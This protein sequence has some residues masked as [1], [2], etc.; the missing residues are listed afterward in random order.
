[1]LDHLTNPRR[2]G[3]RRSAVGL[4]VSLVLHG[5]LAILVLYGIGAAASDHRTPA[6]AT[7]APSI[8]ESPA[9]NGIGGPITTSRYAV[10]TLDLRLAEL[11]PVTTGG[12]PDTMELGRKVPIRF[13]LPADRVGPDSIL[14][15]QTASGDSIALRLSDTRQAT[16]NGAHFVVEPLTPGLQVTN[17]VR[18]SEWLWHVTPTEAGTQPIA[19]QLDAIAKVDGHERVVT[20]AYLPTEVVVHATR[21]QR[22]SRFFSYHWTWLS[23]LTLVALAGWLRMALARR[24]AA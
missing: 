1:M 15:V 8:A 22:I 4:A 20:L 2:A 12:L 19:L 16:L 3:G 9:G 17:R 6:D 13:L 21:I 24:L 10:P 14:S 23:L 5:A 7:H 11:A 18:P